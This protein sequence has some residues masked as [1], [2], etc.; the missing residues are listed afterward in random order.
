M[1]RDRH[2]T[3]VTEPTNWVSSLVVVMKGDKLR[4]YIDPKDF[5]KAIRREHYPIPTTEEVL[6]G[7]PGVKRFSVLDAKSGFLLI[8][9]DYESSLL[10]TFNTP[11]GRY[12]WLRLPFGIRSA[13]EIY[14]RIMDT[15]LEGIPACRDIMDD[16]L[17][18]AKTPIEHDT[19]LSQVV[20]RAKSWN[21]Q[22]NVDKCQ[23]RRSEVKY[24]G[25]LIT[26]QGLKPDPSKVKALQEMPA[27]KSKE[28]VRRF[29]GFIQYLAKFIPNLSEVD[30]SLRKV[31]KQNVTFFL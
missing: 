30:A 19:I 6:A 1:E 5:N 10:T 18:A 21:L 23:I 12:R 11:I 26:S 3:K 27:P 24:V 2:I 14:Q 13:P 25:H 20:Q 22:L 7:M 31:N 17:I 8:K 4:L 15:M 28:E 16:I 29:L 9:L